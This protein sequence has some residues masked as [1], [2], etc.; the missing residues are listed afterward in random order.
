[1]EIKIRALVGAGA[2]KNRKEQ[3]AISQF[4]REQVSVKTSGR[5]QVRKVGTF[6]PPK[7]N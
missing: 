3:F 2:Q 1:M 6:Q 4:S 7:K 5:R